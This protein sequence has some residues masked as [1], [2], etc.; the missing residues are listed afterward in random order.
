MPDALDA[1]V[2]D[3]VA[4]AGRRPIP[5]DHAAAILML[6]FAEEQAAEILTRLEPDEVRQLSEIMYSVADVGA[7]EINE[8]LDLFI[9]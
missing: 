1:V 5:S 7:E 8:V 6:L 9:D 3:G 4:P 2:E